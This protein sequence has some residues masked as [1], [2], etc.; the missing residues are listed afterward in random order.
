LYFFIIVEYPNVKKDEA[1][2]LD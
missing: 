2:S 1:I